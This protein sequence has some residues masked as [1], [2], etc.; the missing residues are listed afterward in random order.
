MNIGIVGLGFVGSVTAAVLADQGHNVIGLDIY[1]A[2]IKKF[3]SE[4]IPIY[5]P[6]LKELI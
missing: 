5:E 4:E 6:G 1:N 3:N 2:K